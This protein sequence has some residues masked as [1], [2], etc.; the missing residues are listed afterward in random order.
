[1]N[2]RNRARKRSRVRSRTKRKDPIY[3]DGHRPRPM[4]VDYKDVELLTKLVNRHGKIVG[5]RKSGCSA[6]S[7][8][9]VTAAVK[10][11]RFMALMPYVGE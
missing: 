11:A 4:Y 8:H 5:R 2:N 7:Q 10:R 6:V 3:V 1:M 9:A